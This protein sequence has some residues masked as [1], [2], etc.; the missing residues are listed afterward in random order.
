MPDTQAT[1]LW[2]LLQHNSLVQGGLFLGVVGGALAYLRNIPLSIYRN[3]KN[4]LIY[5]VTIVS[6]ET[7]YE[8]L[9][10]WMCK[11]FEGKPKTRSFRLDTTTDND[12][13]WQITLIPA[14]GEYMLRYHQAWVWMSVMREKLDKSNF[15]ELFLDTIVIRMFRGNQQLL[16]DIVEEARI[17][18]ENKFTNKLR[19]YTEDSYEGGWRSRVVKNGRPLESV[20]LANG[21]AVELVGEIRQFFEKRDWYQQRGIPWRRGYLLHGEPGNGKTSLVQAVATELARDIAT[22]SLSNWSL[23]DKGLRRLLSD[24]PQNCVVCIEDI[25]AA[26][27]QREK[28]GDSKL[29]FSGL[30]NALDG[31]AS[32]EG[33]VLFMTTNFKEHL[34]SALIRPGRA[35]KHVCIQN[36]TKDQ[37]RRLFLR[38]YQDADVLA[39]R[40]ACHYTEKSASMATLQ[41]YFL[42]HATAE[43]AVADAASLAL[44]VKTE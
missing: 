44:L 23:D 40:F 38:F 1:T 31:L 13:K 25:D 42:G 30:L 8:W 32:A 22:L 24:L 35:D 19:I 9:Q 10:Y 2:S 29:S 34:D 26:F 4:R 36:A 11:Q 27:H 41:E 18:H 21:T 14:P 12:G 33:R 37:A 43:A 3:I 39:E 17:S 28:Q 15:Q 16:K 20:I 5:S 7:A 6:T